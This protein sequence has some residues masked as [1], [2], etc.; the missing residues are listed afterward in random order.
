MSIYDLVSAAK[1]RF[2]KSGFV[3]LLRHVYTFIFGSIIVSLA[4]N[5]ISNYLVKKT[6]IQNNPTHYSYIE[7]PNDET[8]IMTN[9]SHKKMPLQNDESL[10][11]EYSHVFE[12]EPQFV[13]ELNDAVVIG[14]HASIID[15]NGTVVTDS[16]IDDADRIKW[17]LNNAAVSSPYHVW[18]ALQGKEYS[19]NNNKTISVGAVFYHQNNN[20]YHWLI[21]QLLKI[22]AIEYYESQTGRDVSLIFPPQTPEYVYEYLRLLGYHKNRFIEWDGSPLSIS[23]CIVPSEPEPTPEALAWFRERV[24]NSIDH[25][26][27]GSSRLYV[28][29]QK[30]QRGRRIVNY[31]DVSTLLEKYDIEQIYAEDLSVEEQVAA[32]ST[33][34]LIVGPHGAGLTNM[35]WADSTGVLELHN[36]VIKGPF[37]LFAEVLG[38][39]YEALSG[40]PIGGMKNPIYNDIFIDVTELKAKLELFSD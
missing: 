12:F 4:V 2:N 27:G 11:H 31:E 30:A 22:R 17:M 24:V 13:I 5:N 32:F 39:Q 7:I 9:I 14:P 15:S 19:N 6:D 3:S 36:S 21:E 16:V 34:D 33:A 38:Y 10:L 37:Y 25:T 28:S 40:K 20:Y 1:H 8:K 29:R 35:I 26:W 23:T 18:K